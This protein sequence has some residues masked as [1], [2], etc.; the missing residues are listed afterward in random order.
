MATSITL[1][2]LVVDR[3]GTPIG[4]AFN[5][6]ISSSE[7]VVQL[8]RAVKDEMNPY[9]N[10]LPAVT[11]LS[12]KLL[13]PV[14]IGDTIA[15]VEAFNERVRTI[16]FPDPNS[17]GIPRKWNFA[18]SPSPKKAPPILA[19]SSRG[20]PLAFDRPSPSRSRD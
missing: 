12:W 9:L 11:L 10:H 14:P 13:P 7:P 15:E 8:Q 5:V 4:D 2:C 16:Q 20:R 1:Y 6:K 3:D 19:G 18:V 17:S